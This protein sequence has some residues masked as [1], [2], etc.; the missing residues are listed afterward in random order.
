MVWFEYWAPPPP[1]ALITFLISCITTTTSST[2]EKHPH[3]GSKHDIMQN[4]QNDMD[5]KGKVNTN[6]KLQ[7]EFYFHKYALK[8]VADIMS[9][10][11]WEIVLKQEKEE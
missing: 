10:Y 2:W 7:I 11:T 1:H 3:L 5:L 9:I 8:C 4:E 6:T